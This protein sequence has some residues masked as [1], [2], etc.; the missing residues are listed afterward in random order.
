[1]PDFDGYCSWSGAILFAD[2]RE[3]IVLHGTKMINLV[4]AGGNP[5]QAMDLGLSLQVSSLAAIMR[6]AAT[7]A[8]PRGVLEEL[9]RRRDPHSRASAPRHCAGHR[10]AHDSML[11]SV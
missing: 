11:P 1:M 3:V 5:I 10:A 4:A 2:S 8:G 6:G 7:F 9:F